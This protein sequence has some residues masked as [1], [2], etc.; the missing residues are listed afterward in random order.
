LTETGKKQIAAAQPHW[1]A[2]EHR[3]RQMLGPGGWKQMHATVARV[4]NAAAEA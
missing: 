1:Q 3:L 2:A 4:A